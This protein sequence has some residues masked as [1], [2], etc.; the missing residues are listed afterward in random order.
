MRRYRLILALAL[1]VCGILAAWLWLV[2]PETADMAAYAP[3]DS[4]LYLEANRPLEVVQV[5]SNTEAWK[6][7]EKATGS[8]LVQPN[9][10]W[11][12]Q[13]IRWTGIGPVQSVILA[14]AQVAAVVTDLGTSEEGENLQIKPEGAVLI[15]T[16]TS[17]RRIRSPF[18]LAL[19]QLAEKTYGRPTSRRVTLDG[20][21]FIEWLAPDGN[22]QL[23][24]AIVGSLVIL[25]NTERAVQSCVAVSQGRRPKLKDDPELNRV[26]LQLAGGDALS[27]GYV[28]AGNSARLLAVSVPLLLGRAPADSNFQRLITNGA[29]KVFGSLGWTSKPYLTGIEDRYL[30]ALQ[31]SIVSHLRPDF[32]TANTSLQLQ[33]LLPEDVYSVT[34]YRFSNPAA[35]LQSLK[36]A[37]S[38]QVDAL[39]AIVFS[40]L[41]KSALLSY[42]IDDPDRFLGA[43]SEELLTLRLDETAERALLLAGVRDQATLRELISKNM[44]RKQQDQANAA[45]QVELFEDA[46]GEFSA[47]FVS[48]YLIIGSPLDVELYLERTKANSEAMSPERLQRLTFFSSQSNPANIATYTDD[49]NRVRDFISAVRVA[50]GAPAVPFDRLEKALSNLPYSVTETRLDERGLERITRSPLGQFSTLLPL[51]MPEQPSPAR[52]ATQPR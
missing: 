20:V 45:G 16:H 52:D 21:E 14:R 34:D 48:N 37:V 3:A 39:S 44:R 50:R 41:L 51:L 32:R 28:P 47:A 42:G 27:F 10:Q 19:K 18:E 23:V 40:S 5:L 12:Q 29:A 35:T 46:A 31:P 9:R 24:G 30:I 11:L 4:L 26:R 25:G 43:V 38:S 33:R 15:E 22:R 49:R 2:R 17:E 36:A 1:L 13:V 8:P 6:S 7:F